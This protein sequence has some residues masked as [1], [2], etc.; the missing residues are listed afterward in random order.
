MDTEAKNK[1]NY[2]LN[3]EKL[4]LKYELNKEEKIRQVNNRNREINEATLANATRNRAKW[5]YSEMFQLY[6]MKE[7]GMTDQMV[8]IKMQRTLKAV[9]NEKRLIYSDPSLLEEFQERNERANTNQS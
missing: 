5:T 4:Q 3:K 1:I 8:A 2:E 7:A 6:N 9:Q